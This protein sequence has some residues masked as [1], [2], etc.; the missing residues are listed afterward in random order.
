MHPFGGDQREALA[1]VKTHL[2]T[3]DAGGAGT[4]AV[5]LDHALREGV[6]QQVF[7]LLADGAG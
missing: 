3:K 7:V 6:A 1:Q 5:R 2:V 4:G